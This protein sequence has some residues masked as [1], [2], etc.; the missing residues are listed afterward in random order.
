MFESNGFWTQVIQFYV[1]H[2][3][4]EMTEMI[5][6][7]EYVEALTVEDIQEAAQVYLSDEQFIQI[8]L[9]PEQ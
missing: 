6:Y 7:N 9:Y 3:D 2:E 1:E 8:V 4:E 5:Q